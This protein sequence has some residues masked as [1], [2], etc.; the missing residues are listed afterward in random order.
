MREDP[1]IEELV[2]DA[3]EADIAVCPGTLAALEA[4]AVR[5]AGVRRIRSRFCLVASSL[6]AVLAIAVFFGNVFLEDSTADGPTEVKNAVGLLCALDGLDE[7]LVS[8]SP[9]EMLQAWQDAP[10]ADLL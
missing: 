8:F 9:G 10:C 6:A 7:D 4:A 3:L 5:E 1:E 2:K